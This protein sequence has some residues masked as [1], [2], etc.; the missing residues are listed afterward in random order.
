MKNADKIIRINDILEICLRCPNNIKGAKHVE[1][2]D[3]SC[4]HCDLYKELRLLGEELSAN[5]RKHKE[6]IKRKK[7][8]KVTFSINEY[9]Q[10][11]ESNMKDVEICEKY[12]ITS[13]VLLYWKKKHNITFKNKKGDVAT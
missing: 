1:E 12:E 4:G 8:T 5:D 10:M 11:K 2:V 7:S 9:I 3:E 6:P 13:R